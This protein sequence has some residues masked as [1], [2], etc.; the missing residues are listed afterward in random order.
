MKA[1]SNLLEPHSQVRFG[2]FWFFK[3]GRFFYSFHDELPMHRA[4]HHEISEGISFYEEKSTFKCS[5]LTG[6]INDQP[7]LLN[8]EP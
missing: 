5:G 4:F 8:F 6:I 1:K 3:V 2:E 7:E